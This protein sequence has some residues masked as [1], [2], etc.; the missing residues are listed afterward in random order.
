MFIVV[1]NGIW[2]TYISLCLYQVHPGL[3]KTNPE[4]FRIGVAMIL[5]VFLFKLPNTFFR[6]SAPL[7]K[8]KSLW[9][10]LKR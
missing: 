4:P 10:W 5:S 9:Q 7:Q 6:T 1:S 8:P 2:L 3:M